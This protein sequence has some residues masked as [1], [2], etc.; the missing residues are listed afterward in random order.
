MSRTFSTNSGSVESLKV[1]T[2]C[3]RSAKARQMRTT[4]DWLRPVAL[5]SERVLQCVAPGGAASRVVVTARSTCSSVI[6]RGAPGRGSSSRPSSPRSAKRRRHSA[7]VGRLT[8]SASA[9][10]PFVLPGA[11][12][13][14]TIRARVASACPVLR[15]RTQPCSRAR[16]SAERVIGTACGLAMTASLRGTPDHHRPTRRRKCEEIR[17]SGHSH[18][19]R[20]KQQARRFLACSSS[21]SAWPRLGR[22]GQEARS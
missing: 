15:R 17:N 18:V 14:S 9:T 5:A 1:S 22:A 12:Q 20:F 6:L 13:A 7:T 21:L 19:R 3:G 10:P 16:S 11:A 8:P 2:R 4:A